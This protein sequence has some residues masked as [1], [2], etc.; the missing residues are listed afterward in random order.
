MAARAG[1]LQRLPSC[2]ILLQNKLPSATPF[3][4]RFLLFPIL[5]GYARVSADEQDSAARRR[6]LLASGCERIFEETASAGRWDRPRLQELLWQ[7]RKDDVMVVGKLD[8]FSRS[9]KDL[10]HLIE[11]LGEPGAGSRSLPWSSGEGERGRVSLRI[12][13]RLP[14]KP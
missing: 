3:R 12:C 2:G 4:T 1:S 10:L 11:H 14:E 5:L 7:L 6:A 9:F 8:R 13:S